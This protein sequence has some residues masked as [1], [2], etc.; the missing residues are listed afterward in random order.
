MAINTDSTPL[1]ELEHELNRIASE[2]GLSTSEKV[3]LIEEAKTDYANAVIDNPSLKPEQKRTLLEEEMQH[4]ISAI[5][6]TLDEKDKAARD[7]AGSIVEIFKTHLTVDGVSVNIP[8]HQ[9]WLIIEGRFHSL[10]EGINASYTST[11]ALAFLCFVLLH[12]RDIYFHEKTDEEIMKEAWEWFNSFD[13]EEQFRIRNA[14]YR[15]I[16]TQTTKQKKRP[17]AL[18]TTPSGSL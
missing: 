12:C 3:R 7:E 5:K 10:L 17:L 16:E 18:H 15:A 4:T 11:E 13:A 9:F 2:E 1:Q 14:T 8:T 6:K